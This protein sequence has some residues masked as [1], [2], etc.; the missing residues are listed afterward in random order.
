MDVSGLSRWTVAVLCLS[1]SLR[2]DVRVAAAQSIAVTGRVVDAVSGRAVAG[3]QVT[4]GS[5]TI[6]TDAEG[7]FQLDV[8]AGRWEIDVKARDYLPRTIAVD[9]GSQ[10]VA[11]IE[12]QLVPREGFEEHL[13]VTAPEP[14]PPPEGPA[15]LP[16]RPKQVL[17]TAGSLDNPFRTLQTLPG[18]VGTDE[19]GSKLSVRGGAPDQNLT[20]MDGVE[21]HNPYRLFGLTSAFNPETVGRFEL[22]A[23][24]FGARY[25]DRLSSVVLVENR[26]A[27]A[28]RPF[29]GS[30]SA[31]ITDANI[32]GEGRLPGPGQG[33]WLATA[34]R[35]YYDLVAERVRRSGSTRR[36]TTCRSRPRGSFPASAA[37]PCSACAAARSP[38]SRR[39][40]TPTAARRSRRATI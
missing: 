32:I 3:V 26:D 27:D 28:S 8:S 38:A 14:P 10:S 19:F 34:R 21:I 9:A 37:S 23:G 2:L 20:L 31:S 36:S 40:P 30:S 18:V 15:S 12:I 1:G 7:R 24:G 5:R 25:G 16:L 33:S 29:S 13:E 35:T 11:P 17:S 6:V 4:I 22:L 39:R